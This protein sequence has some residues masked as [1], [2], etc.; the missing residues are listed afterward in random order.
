MKFFEM[1]RLQNVLG[2][3][4]PFYPVYD[5]GDAGNAGDTGDAGSASDK[6][7]G[8]KSASDKGT[9]DK[10]FTQTD[11]DRIVQ[12]EKAEQKRALQ[13]RIDELQKFRDSARLSQAEKE[14][15]E[16][17]ITDM[18]KQIETKE[19]QARRERETTA[20]KHQTEI[21]KITE[22]REVWRT[23]YTDSIIR[24]ELT[25]AA[26]AHNAFNSEQVVALLRPNTTVVEILDDDGK[27]TGRYKS[28]VKFE[29]TDDKGKP[30]TVIADPAVVVKRMLDE[31][32]YMNLFKTDKTAGLGVRTTSAKGKKGMPI[33]TADYIAERRKQKQK[34]SN[35]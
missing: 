35:H 23:R 20:K 24:R 30:E 33:E 10:T 14:A 26:V 2:L 18:Q 15:L 34:S 32:R 1:L 6:S 19:E 12:K 27:G 7:A 22:E 13:K 21:A 4:V 25:D 17:Q 3:N 28:Q 8:D 5:D 29:T 16:V 11:V 31:D 9:G